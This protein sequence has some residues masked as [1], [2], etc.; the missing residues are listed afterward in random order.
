MSKQHLSLFL[1][2][3]P[4][5]LYFSRFF[6]SFQSNATIVIVN[7]LQFKFP[8]QKKMLEMMM[9]MRKCVD[10]IACW[11]FCD[12]LWITNERSI[13][14]R[15]KSIFDLAASCIIEMNL[16]NLIDPLPMH[17]HNNH[18]ENNELLPFPFPFFFRPHRWFIQPVTV[19]C[20]RANEV[21]CNFFFCFVFRVFG[22]P[23]ITLIY[24]LPLHA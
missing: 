14:R 9:M 20:V 19:Y 23:L 2:L 6:L 13:L 22:H 11:L 15:R 4:S 1:S 18:L 21:G 16:E 17:T 24:F 10:K 7:V 3:S 8:K 12:F 5:T